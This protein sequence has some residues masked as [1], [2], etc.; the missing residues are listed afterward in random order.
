MIGDPIDHSL[1]PNL[2]RAAYR[3]LGWDCEY[4][5]Y[6]VPQGT[7]V[8][9]F[10][11]FKASPNAVGLSV[12]MPQKSEIIPEVDVLSDRVR[13]LGA[14]NTIYRS[15]GQ[16]CAE[17][18]DVDG[19]INALDARNT[20]PGGSWLIIGAGNT[21]SAAIAAAVEA[22]AADIHFLVRDKTRAEESVQLAHHFG[23]GTS[24]DLLSEFTRELAQE[25]TAIVSTLP[26]RAADNLLAGWTADTGY[27]STLPPLLDVAYD[28]WP[29]QLATA[30]ARHGG[31]VVSGLEM[32][33]YQAIEQIKLFNPTIW[34]TADHQQVLDAMCDAVEL[35]RRKV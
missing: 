1:S 21:A 31:M 16:W 35:P 33:L 15:D 26:P 25:K 17:N 22:G 19:I 10:R 4:T 14:L 32:L 28:P 20:V 12:T 11:S 24:V 2:H 30:W 13:T 6:R 29:S 34:A 5:R 3:V 18:T 23:L 7:G 27:E 9:F 8:E